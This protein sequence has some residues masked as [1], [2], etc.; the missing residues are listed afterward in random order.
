MCPIHSKCAISVNFHGDD[1][2]G[3]DISYKE[4]SLTSIVPAYVL[5][6]Q[7]ILCSCCE[8]SIYFSYDDL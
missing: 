2:T 7:G 3:D 1:G 4:W 5:F 8:W 6:T